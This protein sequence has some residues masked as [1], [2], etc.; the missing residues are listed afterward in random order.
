MLPDEQS[1][2]A[3]DATNDIHDRN[4]D[5]VAYCATRTTTHLTS[6]H[7]HHIH[8]DAIDNHNDSL[9]EIANRSIRTNI[10][11]HNNS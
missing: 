1:N 7:I 5:R 6:Y 3:S 10:S 2:A 11:T 9:L 8:A 4:I